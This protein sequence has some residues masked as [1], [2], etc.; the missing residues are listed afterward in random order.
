MQIRKNLVRRRCSGITKLMK[1][2]LSH[3]GA[4][5]QN[6]ALLPLPPYF[7]LLHILHSIM[8][9]A[10]WRKLPVV[11]VLPAQATLAQPFSG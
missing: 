8:D 4:C 2:E 7:G 6:Q 10:V 5:E 3:F 9:A 1:I 11:Q